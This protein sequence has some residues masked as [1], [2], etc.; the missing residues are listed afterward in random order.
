MHAQVSNEKIVQSMN[1]VAQGMISDMLT[2]F[3][4]VLL[5]KRDQERMSQSI[6]R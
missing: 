6:G 3:S 1:Q 4:E 5:R 2:R